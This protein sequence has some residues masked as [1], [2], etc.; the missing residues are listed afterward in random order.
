MKYF[1]HEKRGSIE[2]GDV[3]F[4]AQ[5][6]QKRVGEMMFLCH[7]QCN[8]GPDAEKVIEEA[9]ET[10]INPEAETWDRKKQ[11]WVPL[12]EPERAEDLIVWA[13]IRVA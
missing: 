1:G 7:T 2:I 4:A 9:L 13:L 8:A 5:D 3:L 6:S 10:L 12:K 11:K